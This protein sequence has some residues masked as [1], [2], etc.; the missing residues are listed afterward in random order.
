[1]IS[2]VMGNWNELNANTRFIGQ[3]KDQILKKNL[4]QLFGLVERE[5]GYD[6]L[7]LPCTRENV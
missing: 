2:E 7:A 6:L 4:K 5:Q 3:G 1:M